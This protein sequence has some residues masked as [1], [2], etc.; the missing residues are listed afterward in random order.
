VATQIL[1]QVQNCQVVSL[2]QSEQ[3]AQR[4]ISLDGL[5]LHQVVGLGVGHDTLGDRRAADLRSLGVA[6]ERAQLVRDLDRLGE[7][8]G[9]GLRTL[10][11]GAGPLAAAIGALGQA[12][13]LLLDGLES[14]RSRRGRGLQVVQVLLQRRDGL[15]E[16]G[17]EILLSSR[18]GRGDLHNS[19]GG[20]HHRGGDLSLDGLLGGLG[21]N[22][23][24]NRGGYGDSLGLRGLLGG[25][26]GG[27]HRVSGGGS[28]CGHGT[29]LC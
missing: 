2:A 28:R 19:R 11:L 21:H 6:Q 18:G 8:A 14:R 26:R 16:G 27:A 3:L 7:D 23:G 25:L 12:G 5:L 22:G 17:T 20:N 9:L 29:Q 10:D 13:S 24:G 15:L 4:R 1:L